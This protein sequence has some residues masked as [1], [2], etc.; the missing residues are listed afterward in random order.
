MAR[1]ARQCLADMRLHSRVGIADTK[2]AARALARFSSVAVAIAPPGK[3]AEAI[4]ALPIAAL[5]GAGASTIDL[6]RTG[7]KSIG[8]LYGV[9]SS[10]LARRFG[11]GLSQ[12]LAASLGQEP[13]PVTPSAVDP[14]YAARMT[15]P[16][17]IGF[18]TDMTKVVERLAVSV[19]S[20]LQAE[21]KGARRY[22]LIIRCVDTGDY[23]IPI[24][25]AR[26][27]AE[28]GLLLQ[29]FAH[30]LDQIK[31]G[32]GADW[33]RLVAEHVE[34]I[35]PRQG[36]MEIS[37]EAADCEARLIST[38]GNRIGFDHVR[39][40]RPH[41]AHLP[42]C[43]FST[44]EAIDHK[45]DPIWKHAPR[46]RPLRLYAKP[47]RLRALVPG[48]PPQQFEWRRRVYEMKSAKGPERLTA[49]W[50]HDNDMRTRDYWSVQTENGARLWLLTYPGEK[51][52]GWF[53]AGRFA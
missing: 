38:L 21:K 34:P 52:P 33:F 9:K 10:E 6:A 30:P 47:E 23:V 50:W 49:Q 24:G 44:Q 28:S 29:Q 11:L 31:I 53:V 22:R 46:K 25:F 19:C 17:P 3:T 20:R 40:F 48:R 35:H 43:E 51:E 27:C 32:F 16:E 26:P 4:S 42:E 41:D 45:F 13:D 8:Q 18:T 39:K 12:S 15:L 2:N 36:V 7:F 37:A 14:V 1:H 5:D